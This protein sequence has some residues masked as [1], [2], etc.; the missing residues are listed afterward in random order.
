MLLTGEMI[1]AKEALRIGLV[2]AVLPIH[3]LLPHAEALALRIIAN[4]P[5][6]AHYCLE[7]VNHGLEGTLE[8][9]LAYESAL[10]GLCFAT[11]DKNEGTK[12][13]LEKRAAQF[14]GV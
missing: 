12:A 8:E 14:K 3:E 6:A 13:F 4:A 10:F 9:G 2:N 7:A 11:A 1:G 5:L